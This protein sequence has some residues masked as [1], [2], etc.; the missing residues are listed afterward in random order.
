MISYSLACSYNSHLPSDSC[1][2]R[3][4]IYSNEYLTFASSSGTPDVVRETNQPDV[5]GSFLEKKP[6]ASKSYKL[7]IDF[8]HITYLA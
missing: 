2:A 7:H 8:V 5:T 1:P 3:I 6:P 4:D